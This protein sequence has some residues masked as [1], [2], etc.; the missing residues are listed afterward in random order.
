MKTIGEKIYDL[1]K[2]KGVSQEKLAD[3]IAVARYSVSR[4]ETNAA[5][6]TT[7]NI[8]AL[9]KFFGVASAY[10][11]DSCDEDVQPEPEAQ[12]VTTPRRFG[13]LKTVSKIGRAHV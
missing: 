9:C 11:L 12:T 2:Q 8:K 10:F 6:P 3:G 13:T 1:R 5:Q 7:E 4:W